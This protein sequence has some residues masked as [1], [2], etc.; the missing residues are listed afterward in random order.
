MNENQSEVFESNQ[1][2]AQNLDK[3]DSL[4]NFHQKFFVPKQSN[5]EDVLY[6]TGN[7]LGL[8]PK[9]TRQFIEQELK[10]W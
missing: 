3:T 9:T 1:S 10:D 5:G 4:K 2:F 6:F 8:Q 7:S